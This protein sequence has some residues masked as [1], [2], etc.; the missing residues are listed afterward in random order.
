MP[1]YVYSLVKCPFCDE[2][3]KSTGLHKHIKT[4]G[5][6]KWEEYLSSKDSPKYVCL[7]ENSYKCSMCDFTNK[8]RQ[9][10]TSHWWRNHTQEGK[11]HSA[12]GIGP[13]KAHKRTSPAWNKGL[14][15]DTHP[16]LARPNQKG[17][18]FGAA[19]AG[20]SEETKRKLS[21]IMSVNNKGGKCKWYDVAGQKVQGTWER[22]CALKFEELGIAWKKL[23]T[24]K[25]VLEYVMDN[26]IR[27][28]TPDFYL[29]EFD[30]YL[31]IKGHW[32][33]KD[34]QKMNMVLKTH[35]NK[36]IIIV[37]KE[38]YKR[39]LDGEQVWLL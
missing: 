19:L 38:M 1:K 24:N 26:K 12:Y 25:D 11:T 33:G 10:V 29:S 23:K 31:E 20:H 30:V 28:Y 15:K 37:E 17:K 27:S 16:S 2:E 13:K 35:P 8:T 5:D 34:R 36:N 4:H 32:W 39:I 14:S 22:N 21:R 18:K 3:R 9:S 6:K 7:T